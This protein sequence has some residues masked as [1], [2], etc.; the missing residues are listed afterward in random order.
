MMT[1]KLK[2]NIEQQPL[3]SNQLSCDEMICASVKVDDRSSNNNTSVKQYISMINDEMSNLLKQT[4]LHVGVIELD[5]KNSI[6]DNY[7]V[8]ER[9]K[10]L[11]KNIKTTA[12]NE[13]IIKY[14]KTN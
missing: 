14:A 2:T 8:H 4:T 10:K 7:I 3:E 12:Y 11:N 6:T 13:E 1:K 9:R 5:S